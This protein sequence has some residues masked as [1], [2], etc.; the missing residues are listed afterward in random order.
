M[1]VLPLGHNYIDHNYT[2][3]ALSVR[4]S[5]ADDGGHGDMATW[6]H[7]DMVTWCHGDMVTWSHG[8][9]GSVD[10]EITRRHDDAVLR[11]GM[12]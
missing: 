10:G 11:S 5:D 9:E 1:L 6:R 2:I 12:S 4:S 8:D 3:M 7:G